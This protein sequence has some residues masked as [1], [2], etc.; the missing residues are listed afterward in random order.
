METSLHQ[1]LKQL[2]STAGS[3]TEAA[4]LGY[5]ADVLCDGLVLEIQA[6]PLGAIARKVADLVQHTQ[7]LVVK[8]IAARKIIVRRTLK[9]KTDVSR[10]LSPKKGKLLDVFDE[11]VRFTRVFPHPNLTIEI[12]LI[13]EE[14]IRVPR[15]RRRFRRP[16]FRIE[17]RRLLSVVSTHRLQTA[18]DLIRLL[19]PD[20]PSTFTSNTLAEWLGG[21]PMWF[22][23]RIAYTLRHCGAARLTGKLGNNLVY[24]LVPAGGESSEIKA[25][26]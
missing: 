17:D 24:E 14:E 12:A 2:Y 5:R 9:A 16:D 26:S 18:D 11:L 19:P 10:R 23:R 22:A 13:E 3:R 1:S 8:P 25:A 20:L 6:S 15:R 7:V 4:V 21:L